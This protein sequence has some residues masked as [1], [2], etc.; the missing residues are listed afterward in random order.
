MAKARWSR[1]K[2]WFSLYAS[3]NIAAPI[4][5]KLDR[6]L[7]K[8]LKFL[9]WVFRLDQFHSILNFITNCLLNSM[10]SQ[11]PLQ[12]HQMHLSKLHLNFL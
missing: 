10:E 12:A 8:R 11:F 6:S 3:D 5:L 9:F 7:L 4:D 1:V 2:I